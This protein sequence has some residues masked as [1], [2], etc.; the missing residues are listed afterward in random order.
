MNPS[1]IPP[2]LFIGVR[3]TRLAGTC[4]ENVESAQEYT[5]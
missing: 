4:Q 1:N 5:T 3:V 2:S